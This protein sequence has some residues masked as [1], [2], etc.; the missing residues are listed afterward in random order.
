[1]AQRL[2][3]VLSRALAAPAQPVSHLSRLLAFDR[4][5]LENIQASRE[6]KRHIVGGDL[7]STLKEQLARS[8][9]PA[10]VFREEVVQGHTL[11]ERASRIATWVR[12][13]G[14]GVGTS[15]AINCLHPVRAIEGILGA[16]FSGA[17]YAPMDPLSPPLRRQQI[18][19]HL[20]PVCILSD[21]GVEAAIAAQPSN[22]RERRD[23]ESTVIDPRSAAYVIYTSG[24]SGVPKGVV[25]SHDAVVAQ[26]QSRV[27]LRFPHA[28]EAL[29][30][31]PLFYD[32]SVETL[33]WTLTTGGTLHV[34]DES[35][36]KDPGFLRQQV[37]T[38]GIT[39]TSA[40]PTLWEAILDAD[41]RCD[42][43]AALA[44]VI[45]GGEALTPSLIVKHQAHTSARLVNE[46]GPTEC[47]VFTNAWE[48]P[49][50]QYPARVYI[51]GFAP[52]VE[53]CLVDDRCVKVPAGQ[54][55]EL[56][57]WGKGLAEGYYREAESYRPVLRAES[58]WCREGV[59]DG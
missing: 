29:L 30:L 59:P 55:G 28:E 14:G 58:V 44:F 23:I 39:Y 21:A 8:S 46:Y 26:L 11:I 32:G 10:L 53:G 13:Q 19:D 50:G 38:K 15:V 18:L 7:V 47:T 6:Q 27:A 43:L 35:E 34:S 17:A 45:V 52:H 25:V 12:L 31:A 37:S 5:A 54:P 22:T 40:V 2:L 33:F 51:G 41:P 24:S 49:A 1:M 9:R 56:L 42:D 4:R 36:R 3:A 57:I 20:R 16:L 48:V